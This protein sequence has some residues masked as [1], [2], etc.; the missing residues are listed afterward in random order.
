MN[1]HKITVSEKVLSLA[2][3]APL[4]TVQVLTHQRTE[5]DD[6]QQS[7]DQD[8]EPVRQGSVIAAV[9]IRLV[10]V[11]HVGDLEH[12]IVQ[13]SFHQED[14]AVPEHVHVDTI[15]TRR[16]KELPG[17]AEKGLT[18]TVCY[19]GRQTARV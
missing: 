15:K 1:K 14:P 6:G 13:E 9:R 8:A 11:G 2:R 16:Q 18:A 10:D 5:G 3:V 12:L 7:L 17:W 19:R 4:L